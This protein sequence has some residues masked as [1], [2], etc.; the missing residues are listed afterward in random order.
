MNVFFSF[1]RDFFFQ[2]ETYRDRETEFPCLDQACLHLV[3]F[4]PLP[5]SLEMNGMALYAPFAVLPFDQSFS[6][7]HQ[8]IVLYGSQAQEGS[9]CSNGCKNKK[10]TRGRIQEKLGVD[11]GNRQLRQCWARWHLPGN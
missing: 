10:C 7:I 9:C 1:F 11:A 3:I 6:L 4:L 8:G 2:R 5:W